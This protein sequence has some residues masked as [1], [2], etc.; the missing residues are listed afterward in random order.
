MHHVPSVPVS[1]LSNA[2]RACIGTGRMG[3]SLWA[4]HGE[5][6]RLAARDIG[7]EY[8]RGHGIFHEDMGIYRETEIDGAKTVRYSFLYLDQ[9]FD[10][11]LDAGLKPLLELGFMPK[12]LAS[13]EDTVFWWEGN[14]TPP[15]SYDAWCELVEVTLT[16]LIERYGID[17][18]ATWPIEVWNEPNLTVFWKDAD[19][20]EYFRLYERT[21]RAI[22]AIDE[23]LQ[24]GGPVLSPGSDEWWAPFAAFI[25]ES[26]APIDFVSRHAYTSGP[27]QHVPFGVYQ[28]LME[29]AA[30]VN[31]FAIPS[32]Y[33]ADTALAGLPVHISEF[34]TSY[35]PDSP[36]HDTAYNA[37]YLAPVLAGGGATGVESFSY[38][39]ISDIFEEVG[40]PRALF[41]GGF[42]LLTH[43]NIPKPTYHLYSFMA[44]MGRDV[45]ALGE[46]HLVTRHEDGRVTVLAWQPVD[47]SP[48]TLNAS[49]TVALNLPVAGGDF[50]YVTRR[51]VNETL[52]N[53]FT[54]W[55]RMG[56]P[57]APSR[58]HMEALRLAAVPALENLAL[59]VTD[60]RIELT[61][62]LAQ[63]EVTLVELIPSVDHT[64]PW[65][66]D[67]RIPG[68]AK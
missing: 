35:R 29:P 61:L 8:I 58:R 13:G 28:T 30:L 11:Y 43:G 31:Q 40:I 12:D 57:A 56:R 65:I 34:N 32:Q 59:P 63:H 50:A 1:Q 25:E 15:A 60:G 53:A 46:D 54:A 20:Q 37:A 22:K 4:G 26:G 18:V 36:V 45:L 44:Q 51:R 39:T 62:E 41:H 6:L 21:A 3:L 68:Y 19:Q 24:V 49:H 10:S 23:R 14:I 66:D 16:H 42:G 5:A 55:Q 27:A 38:W 9:V 17:E 47:G 7:F 64:E 48:V 52:G 67:T 33:L 2:W